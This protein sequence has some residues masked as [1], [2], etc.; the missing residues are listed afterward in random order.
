MES[1]S[2]LM[3][4]LWLENESPEITICFDTWKSLLICHSFQQSPHRSRSSANRS[5]WRHASEQGIRSCIPHW[6]DLS[7]WK[8]T[9]LLDR[10]RPAGHKDVIPKSK[11]FCD[12]SLVLLLYF[13]S[14]SK[15][16]C[17]LNAFGFP[18]C[19][20]K[21]S[22]RCCFWPNVMFD[23][24]LAWNLQGWRMSL[25][26]PS[27]WRSPVPDVPC[28]QD[29]VQ[30]SHWCRSCATKGIWWTSKTNHKAAL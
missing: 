17:M 15:S 28:V 2:I 7:A 16:K 3:R 21:Q 20:S 10:S 29:L 19:L 4:K 11:R 24:I 26:E 14:Y 22:H 9:K 5:C 27:A 12:G 30:L 23:R 18:K 1:W 25:I 13:T 6:R 8:P